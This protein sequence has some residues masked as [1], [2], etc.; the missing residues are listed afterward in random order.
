MTAMIA[1]TAPVGLAACGASRVPGA[2][3]VASAS[4]ATASPTSVTAVATGSASPVSAPPITE[5]PTEGAPSPEP[6]LTGPAV[7]TEADSGTTI[8]LRT[9]DQV[10]IVLGPPGLAMPWD[11]PAAQGGAVALVTASGGYPT[12]VPARAVFKALRPG[13]ARLTSATDAKCLHLPAA[14]RCLPPQQIWEVTI[15]VPAG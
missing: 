12:N 8:V 3:P 11:Q 4:S 5:L 15:I 13:T 7:L 10:T 9:G 2:S 14:A 6:T 1:I